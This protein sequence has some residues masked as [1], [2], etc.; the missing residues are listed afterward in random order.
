MYEELGLVYLIILD[1]FSCNA[2]FCNPHY[3]LGN[4]MVYYLP[5]D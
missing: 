1:K 5:T 4:L 3:Q 2:A